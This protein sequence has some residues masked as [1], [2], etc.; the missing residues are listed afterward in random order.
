[1]YA[2]VA[3]AF[4]FLLSLNASDSIFVLIFFCIAYFQTWHLSTF[5]VEVT[6]LWQYMLQSACYFLLY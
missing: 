4:L 5:A 6:V 1:M 3:L 2:S